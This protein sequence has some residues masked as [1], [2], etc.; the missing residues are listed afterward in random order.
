MGGPR[1]DVWG[2]GGLYSDVQGIMD[3]SH[4]GTPPEQNDIT[5][6]PLHWRAVKTNLKKLAKADIWRSRLRGTPTETF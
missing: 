4:M 3:N 2:G 6:P 1:S 5:F